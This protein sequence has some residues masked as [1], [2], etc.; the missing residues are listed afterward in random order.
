MNTLLL[1]T[2]SNVAVVWD[3][4]VGINLTRITRNFGSKRIKINILRNHNTCENITSNFETDSVNFDS[5]IVIDFYQWRKRLWKFRRVKSI[6]NN[7]SLFRE[8]SISHFDQTDISSRVLG[9]TFFGPFGF[10]KKYL[11]CLNHYPFADDGITIRSSS[12]VQLFS[13]SR[14]FEFG[15]KCLCSWAATMLWNEH[16]WF[17]IFLRNCEQTKLRVIRCTN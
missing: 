1:R 3:F 5:K 17:D 4:D 11:F 14:S 6:C 15:L 8:L 9:I 2:L 10:E 12:N 13:C 16:I 7:C